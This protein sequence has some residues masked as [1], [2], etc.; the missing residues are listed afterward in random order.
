VRRWGLGDWGSGA[1]KQWGL[2]GVYRSR[3]ATV[4]SFWDS[5]FE[6]GVREAGG[7]GLGDGWWDQWMRD[8]AV[9]FFNLGLI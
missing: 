9:E 7:G 6:F 3:R 2:R 8:R 4:L 5:K 1:R